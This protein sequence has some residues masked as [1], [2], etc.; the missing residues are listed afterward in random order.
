VRV[1]DP[2]ARQVEPGAADEGGVALGLAQLFTHN[3]GKAQQLV[4]LAGRQR[5]RAVAKRRRCRHAGLRPRPAARQRDGQRQHG[6]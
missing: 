6:A 1:A 3:G 4:L 2:E 5:L